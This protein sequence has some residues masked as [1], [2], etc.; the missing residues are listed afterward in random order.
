MYLKSI[1]AQGFKS[2]ADKLD[3]EIKDG[4]TAI[5][6]PNGSGKSNIVDAVRWV[7]GE[8]SVKSL[9]G[10][11]NM[12]D[13]IFSGSKDR[14]MQSRAM[15]ALTFDNTDHYFNSD[16]TE[17]E[18]KRIVYRSGENEYLI[19]GSKV[20][21]KDITNLFIDSGAGND[22]FNIISQ[23]NI[24][25]VINSKPEARRTIFEEAAGV[26][27]Y[28]KRKEESLRK[29]DKTKE[30][31]LRI[32]LVIDELKTTVEP[33]KEQ[34]E[35]AKRYVALKDELKEIEIGLITNDI[36]TINNEYQTLKM[37]IDTLS[38]ELLDK[39]SLSNTNNA[40]IESL[41]LEIT[42][43]EENINEKNI[44]LIK[45]NNELAKLNADKDMMLE[46]K[47]Y[48]YNSDQ[49]ASFILSAKE[50]ISNY[51]KDKSVLEADINTFKGKYNAS[52][53]TK[54]EYE[55]DLLTLKVNKTSLI[56][57][58]QELNKTILNTE[59]KIDILENNIMSNAKLP[60]A[61]QSILSN[62]RFSKIYGTISSLV[63]TDEKYEQALETALG[64]GT[65]FLVAEDEKV[66]KNAIEFLKENKLGKA[67]FFPINIIKPR[68]VDNDIIERLGSVN[69]YINT[70]NNLV[71]CEAKYRDVIDNQVGNVIVVDNIDSMNMIGRIIEYKYRIVTLDGEIL[72]AGGSITGGTTKKKSFISEKNELEKL[73]YDLENYKKQEIDLS[74]ELDKTNE[75]EEIINNNILE[76]EKKVIS[77]NEVIDQKINSLNDINNNID[78]VKESIKAQESLLGNKLDSEIDKIMKEYTSKLTSKELLEKELKGIQDKKLEVS[79]NLLEEEN[80]LRSQNSEYNRISNELKEK[81]IKIGKFDVKLDNLLLNLSENYQLTYEKAKLEYH[82]DI[83]EKEARSKVN[84]IKRDINSLGEVNVGAI[85]EYERLGQRYEFLTKQQEDLEVASQEL[86]DVIEEMDKIMIDKFEVTFNKISEEFSKV[87]KTLFKGGKGILKLTDPENILTTGIEIIAEPPGKKLNSIISLSGGEKTLTAIALLFAILNVKTVPFIILD[88]AEAALDEANVD[89]FGEYIASKKDKSQF[90]L[91]THKKRT[92]E[93]ADILYGITMQESGVSKIVSVKLEDK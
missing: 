36:S 71:N 34:S 85:A 22:S 44:E 32:N 26:L 4:I 68:Y 77:F 58:I 15:V 84:S 86:L 70:L 55:N 19:N 76:T 23:G 64:A 52:L 92:M 62:P 93:Y 37:D 46:R 49:V 25:D 13:V 87:F 73:K 33:L 75:E 16:F 21:L 81:E 2:F 88:E 43:L 42:K 48:E 20:R 17:I 72:H 7:L 9:R 30:N 31:L 80:K 1:K 12:T 78:K 38:E 90:I 10:S 51:E 8:Q 91:I 53:K 56:T 65:N 39:E 83:D 45:A 35:I 54:Q 67:T 41:K 5:V 82:L 28:K 61:V 69:G 57:K 59:N 89:T 29:L 18:I 27:K 60:Y 40:L 6:G 11:D 24:A 3:L 74:K 63:E 66:I 50:E 79:N 14:P 47:K